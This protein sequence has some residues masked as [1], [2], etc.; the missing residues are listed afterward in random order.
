MRVGNLTLIP[1]DLIPQDLCCP[2]KAAGDRVHFCVSKPVMLFEP[3]TVI[4]PGYVKNLTVIV[5]YYF[6]VLAIA[7]CTGTIKKGECGT[8]T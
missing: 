8:V 4:N 6:T 2:R 3:H 5:R 7:E 1:Q